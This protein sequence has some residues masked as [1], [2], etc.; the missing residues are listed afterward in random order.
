MAPSSSSSSSSPGNDDVA[1]PSASTPVPKFDRERQVRYFVQCLLA[2]E[3]PEP[4]CKLDTN[5]LTLAHFAVH[6]L[7]LLGVVWE[8]EDDEDGGESNNGNKLGL[9]RRGIVEWIYSLLVVSSQCRDGDDDEEEEEEEDVGT[10][11]RVVCGFKGGTFLGDDPPKAYDQGHIAM[12]YTALCTLRAL[13]DDWGRRVDRKGVARSLRQFQ[14]LDGSFQCV[15]GDGGSESDMRFLYCA[16][17]ISAMLDDWSGVD[18]DRA[19]AYIKSCRSYDGAVGLVPGQEGHGG[20]TFCA[21]ASLVLMGKLEEVIGCDDDDDDD[22][23]RKDLVRWCTHRQVGGMQGR[24]NK[25]EDTCYSYWIVGT[26]RLLGEDGLIRHDLLRSYVLKCQSNHGGF[27][28]VIG[29]FPDLLHSYYS[30]AY[31]SMSQPYVENLGLKELNCTLGIS[32]DTANKL[33]LSFP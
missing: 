21:I 18:M 2:N 6:A 22:N 31:L 30:L 29:A 24:P 16:C 9:N 11:S 27:G 1:S 4:Y 15:D 26:L 28:K 17:S 13:G 5:R 10:T 7:D 8:D 12:T 23:W 32:A 20:S 33:M 3:L 19:V 25:A 14:R